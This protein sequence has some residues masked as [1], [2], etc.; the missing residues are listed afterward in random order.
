LM[1]LARLAS[2]R[3]D[4]KTANSF[5]ELARNI[6]PSNREVMVELVRSRLMVGAPQSLSP[7]ERAAIFSDAKFESVPDPIAQSVGAKE[8]VARY[9]SDLADSIATQ[10]DSL[11]TAEAYAA[12]VK[13]RPDLARARINLSKALMMSGRKDQALQT[14][15][16]TVKLFPN[17]SMGHYSYS[18]ALESAERFDEAR[19]EREIAVQIKPD[20]AQ[21]WYALATSQEKDGDLVLAE[22]SYRRAV[23]SDARMAQAHLALGILLQK[24]DKLTE[25]IDAMTTSVRLVPNEPYPRTILE[26]TQAQLKAKQP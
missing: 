20:Y 26:Q 24:Q 16:E 14:L 1:A 6:A 4:W 13:K 8:V 19:K 9:A 25:A 10:G 21:A 5:L 3:N 15:Q 22:E 7:A 17:D 11:Q 23:L 2:S 18:L 12:L